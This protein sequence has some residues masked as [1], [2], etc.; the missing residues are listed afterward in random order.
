M[1]LNELVF[2]RCVASGD[3]V[4][5]SREERAALG[6]YEDDVDESSLDFHRL[7]YCDTGRGALHF[8]FFHSSQELLPF[9][10][11]EVDYP[12]SDIP[13]EA[14]ISGDRREVLAL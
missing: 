10:L 5:E 8:E 1:L 7:F 14:G 2:V 9:L 3:E 12:A 11:R 13:T 4:G 6:A